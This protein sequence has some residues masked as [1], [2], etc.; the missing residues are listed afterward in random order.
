[1]RI[2]ARLDNHGFDAIAGGFERHDLGK[3][4]ASGLGGRVRAGKRVWHAVYAT[5]CVDEKTLGPKYRSDGPS[6]A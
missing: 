3:D 1:M 4:I 5:A 2:G 6:V